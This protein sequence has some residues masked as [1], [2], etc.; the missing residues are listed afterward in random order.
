MWQWKRK[1]LQRRA[2]DSW[3]TDRCRVLLLLWLLFTL[4]NCMQQHWTHHFGFLC[5]A[6]LHQRWCCHERVLHGLLVFTVICLSLP[7][8]PKTFPLAHSCPWPF[9]KQWSSSSSSEGGRETNIQDPWGK[10]KG[11]RR[12]GGADQGL[13]DFKT[14]LFI[15]LLLIRMIK[16]TSGLLTD[17]SD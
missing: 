17:Y 2:S 3:R 16:V 14:E 11:K 12:W 5:K 6:G 7:V 1:E 9:Y 13:Y 4:T 15:S 8:S 10:F